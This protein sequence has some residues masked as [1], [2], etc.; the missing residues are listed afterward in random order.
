[1]KNVL[2]FKFIGLFF[3]SM[4]LFSNL[5]AQNEPK[6]GIRAGVLISKLDFQ[7]GNLN[8]DTK[9][10]FGLDLGL[11]S[12]FPIGSVVS[13]GPEFHWLQKGSKIE[14]ITGG[15]V[16]EITST[17]NYLELPVLLKLHFGEDVG[18][19]LFAGPSFGYLLDG[20]DK[21]HDG[22]TND[23]DLDFYK[24]VEFGFHAGG[25]IVLGPLVIDIRYIYGISNISDSEIDLR[26]RGLG[27]GVSLIF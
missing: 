19:M 26:N 1:M 10:K 15:T 8:Q 27:A 2:K 9:S 21:D 20:K 25:G 22:N 4:F 23:I 3:F 17:L 12:D 11:V 16:G 6:V 13:I 18:F 7:N 14:D 24:R 5:Q